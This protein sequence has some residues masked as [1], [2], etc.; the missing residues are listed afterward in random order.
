MTRHGPT[1]SALRAALAAAALS[2]A[3]HAV[4]PAGAAGQAA[5]PLRIGL[6]VGAEH[7]ASSNPIWTS[8]WRLAAT[9]QRRFDRGA[10]VLETSDHRRFG[11]WDAAL[12]TDGYLDLW[13]GSYG[14]LRVQVAPGALV[15]PRAD[16]AAELFQGFSG[17]EASVAYRHMAF[18]ADNVNVLG[19]SLARYVGAWYLQATGNG[20]PGSAGEPWALSL[21]GRVR[22]YLREP[23]DL[24]ELTAGTGREVV[25]LG[26]G[27][28]DLRTT[29]TV[30]ARFQTYPWPHMGF[31]AGS[32]YTTYEG[33]PHR[34]GL[35]LGLL[36]RF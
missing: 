21:V 26:G 19:L 1:P 12:R 36:R 30:A 14:S 31:S 22:R 17:W 6:S 28:F 24:V 25:V 35:D 3:V 20:V 18:A 4:V 8:W 33:V 11:R 7:F 13:P 32:T 2:L 27:T 16:L 29:R 34:I 10:L 9:A 5:P 15:I 23:D